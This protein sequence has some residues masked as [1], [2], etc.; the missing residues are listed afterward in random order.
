MLVL[1]APGVKVLMTP[2]AGDLTVN[3]PHV[4][5]KTALGVLVLS[6]R[7]YCEPPL[8]DRSNCP[9]SYGA[10]DTFSR[11]CYCELPFPYVLV[12][13]ALGVLVLVTH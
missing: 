7:C 13:T 11:L 12:Q 2:L 5:I 3:R 8:C 4:L 6:S 10:S 1:T 9:G